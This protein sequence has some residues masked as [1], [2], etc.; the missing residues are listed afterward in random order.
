MCIIHSNSESH[1]NLPR[2]SPL[3]T[4]P[5]AAVPLPASLTVFLFNFAD[6]TVEI[7]VEG[8]LN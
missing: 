5:L 2:S 8:R 1:E 4:S 3:R 6:S 7:L